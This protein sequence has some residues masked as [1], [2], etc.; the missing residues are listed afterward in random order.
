MVTRVICY[1]C[2]RS[3]K[4][5]KIIE[6]KGELKIIIESCNECIDPQESSLKKEFD[7]HL[8]D[9]LREEPRNEALLNIEYE[10]DNRPS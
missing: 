1:K 5:K 2:K 10:D 7:K 4:V 9:M 8:R 3:L 6:D